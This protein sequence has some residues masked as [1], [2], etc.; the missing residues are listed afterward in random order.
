MNKHITMD[1]FGDFCPANWEEI[2]NF[3][4]DR[5]DEIVAKY[6]DGA[7]YSFDCEVELDRL[8]EDYCYGNLDGA[9]K[10]ATVDIN[11]IPDYKF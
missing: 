1:S 8:W 9:P 4:N 6:G 10:P 7:E 11:G 3:L 2:A 5:I